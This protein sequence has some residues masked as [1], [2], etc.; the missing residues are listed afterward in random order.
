MLE[1]KHHDTKL[2]G[3]KYA[4]SCEF[5]CAGYRLE[6]GLVF[7]TLRILIEFMDSCCSLLRLKLANKMPNKMIII[8]YVNFAFLSH[9]S[10]QNI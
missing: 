7:Y 10:L 1:I 3:K 2:Q 4:H 8:T 9:N 5:Q 6:N